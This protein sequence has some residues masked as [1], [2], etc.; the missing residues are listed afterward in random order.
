MSGIVSPTHW[1]LPFIFIV[2]LFTSLVL[3]L[4]IRFQVV[5]SIEVREWVF[6]SCFYFWNTSSFS[7]FIKML[8]VDWS[9]IAFIMLRYSLSTPRIF[10]A[11]ITKK[12]R[13]L[14]K[15]LCLVSVTVIK[16]WPKPIRGKG[17]YFTG[18]STAHQQ[19]NP[20][21]KLEEELGCM[22]Q[23]PWRTLCTG[24]FT[25]ACSETVV[26]HSRHACLGMTQ[27]RVSWVLDIHYQ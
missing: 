16:C 2:L 12:C 24:L 9:Y 17:G 13:I 23:R 22:Q 1:L 26:M 15:A 4:C 19:R 7:S 6:L 8:A 21:Q 11:F 18:Q 3:L 14:S 27:S 10:R 20:E 25:L 5:Y